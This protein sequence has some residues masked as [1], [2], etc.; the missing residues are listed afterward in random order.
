MEFYRKENRVFIQPDDNINNNHHRRLAYMI[1][2][3]PPPMVRG[4]GH[5]HY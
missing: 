3:M 1:N 2:T 5:G 4:C